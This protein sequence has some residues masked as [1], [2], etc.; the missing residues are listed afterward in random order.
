MIFAIVKSLVLLDAVLV[1]VLL[2]Y[3]LGAQELGLLATW[4]ILMTPLA[5][6]LVGG[7][8]LVIAPYLF[9]VDFLKTRIFRQFGVHRNSEPAGE[10]A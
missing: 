8:L 10:I 2:L 7:L 9:G 4:G 5:P 1:A 3:A 6:T